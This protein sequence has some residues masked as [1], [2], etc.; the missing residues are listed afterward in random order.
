MLPVVERR[1]G[2]CVSSEHDVVR[3]F[4]LVGA[5]RER[6]WCDSEIFISVGRLMVIM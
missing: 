6:L 4:S 2:D 1:S 5:P 3:A